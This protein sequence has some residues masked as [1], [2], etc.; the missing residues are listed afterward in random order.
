MTDYNCP[1]D[2]CEYG[3]EGGKSL[4][5]VRAHIN[6]SKTD[7]HDWQTHKADV[8]AQGDDSGEPEGEQTE[9]ADNE[10]SDTNGDEYEQQFQ[11]AARKPDAIED[12][13]DG[14]DGAD[15]GGDSGKST[16]PGLAVLAGTAALGLAV[17]LGRGNSSEP[18]TATEPETE[19]ESAENSDMTPTTLR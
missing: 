7:G 14:D 12:P 19:T 10:E 1:V 15:D 9:A 18:S 17:I 11:D 4:A 13:D 5:A 3:A 16:G 6:A 8:E 2:G